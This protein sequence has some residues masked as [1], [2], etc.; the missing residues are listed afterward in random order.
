[1]EKEFKKAKRILKNLKESV[2]R[3][4]MR[5]PLPIKTVEDLG[6]RLRLGFNHAGGSPPRIVT[7]RVAARGSK[8]VNAN[9]ESFQNHCF[10]CV[11]WVFESLGGL[12]R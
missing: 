4:A 9:H 3:R 1:M 7:L 6:K 2:P 11:F 5:S 10:Y 8:R 12:N